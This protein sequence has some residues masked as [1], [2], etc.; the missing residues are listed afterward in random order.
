[1]ALPVDSPAVVI[2]DVM[3]LR[4]SKRERKD[5]LF[6]VGDFDEYVSAISRVLPDSALVGIVDGTAANRNWKHDF[7][8]EEDQRELLRRSDLT[9]DQA[10]Y[11][12]LLPRKEK[13]LGFFRDLR[14]INADP[15]CVHLLEQFAP[16][17]VV[18]TFDWMEKPEDLQYFPL[19]HE[20][21]SNLYFPFWLNSEQTLVFLSRK[22]ASRF[23]DGW[24]RRFNEAVE[25][26]DVLRVENFLR[27]AVFSESEISERRERA[28]GYV[29]DVVNEHRA[30]GNRTVPIVLRWQKPKSPFDALDPTEFPKEVPTQVGP[31]ETPVEEDQRPVVDV[32]PQVPLEAT[33]EEIDLIRSIDELRFFVGKRVRVNAMMKIVDD[34]AILTWLGAAAHIQLVFNEPSPRLR[35]GFVRV[36]GV[37]SDV[38]GSLILSI[39]APKDVRPESLSDTVTR[40]LG[41]L[42]KRNMYK[43]T[44][45]EWGFPALPGWYR[46]PTSPTSPAAP[47]GSRVESSRPGASVTSRPTTPRP[48]TPGARPSTAPRTPVPPPVTDPRDPDPYELRHP[49]PRTKWFVGLTTALLLAA[50]IALLVR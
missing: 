3:N 4:G 28:Y 29:H 9:P 44:G 48:P 47:G 8:S 20:L 26:R 15:V 22:Q 37:V 41:R 11:L 13:K 25:R 43:D 42:V 36:E 34:V 6:S 21:R 1:V 23:T 38:N 40:R 27:S 46:Q 30:A 19:D 49:Q 33:T 2:L 24:N 7:Q 39:T 16:N 45:D 32:K 10:E 5:A 35:S 14:Y 50:T 17:A 18:I 31:S 12:H